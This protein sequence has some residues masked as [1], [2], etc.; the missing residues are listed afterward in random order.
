MNDFFDNHPRRL[1]ADVIPPRLR[2]FGDVTKKTAILLSDGRTVVFTK[3][4]PDAVREKYERIINSIDYGN[5][6]KIIHD[7]TNH[8]Q[9]KDAPDV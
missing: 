2:K 7:E 1:T 9:A 4:K 6:R 3:H 5:E 8:A